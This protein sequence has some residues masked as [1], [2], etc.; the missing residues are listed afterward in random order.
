MEVVKLRQ[1]KQ[2]Q[3]SQQSLGIFDAES[4]PNLSRLST[5]VSRLYYALIIVSFARTTMPDSVTW[6][7]FLSRSRS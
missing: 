3:K 4:L 5:F 7:S 6:K 1:S 2:K